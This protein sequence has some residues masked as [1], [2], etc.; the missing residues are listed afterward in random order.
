MSQHTLILKKQMKQLKKN[1]E[2]RND[3]DIVLKLFTPDAQC[4]WLITQIEPNGDTM[5][6]LCDL[7]MDC[8]EY[9]TVS[10]NEIKALRG[11]MGLP[12]ERD[13]HFRGGKVSNFSNRNTLAGA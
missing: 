2:T 11:R 10:L 7:N 9:G 3:E 5:W 12:V 8:V 6:G 4:T 13:A 1:Y